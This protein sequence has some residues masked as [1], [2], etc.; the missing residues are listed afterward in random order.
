MLSER[1]YSVEAIQSSEVD[2]GVLLKPYKI[3]FAALEIGKVALGWKIKLPPNSGIKTSDLEFAIEYEAPGK[4]PKSEVASNTTV[5]LNNLDKSTNYTGRI[6]A[7]LDDWRSD[8][9]SFTF[10]TRD[11]GIVRPSLTSIIT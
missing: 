9:E 8:S 10:R 2:L 3:E 4:A 6:T 1:L 5:E 11:E 7:T